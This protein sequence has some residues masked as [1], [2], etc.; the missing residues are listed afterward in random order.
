MQLLS[1]LSFYI[2]VGMTQESQFIWKCILQGLTVE[3]IATC[4]VLLVHEIWLMD[5]DQNT[6]W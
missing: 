2:E 6:E 3:L 4:W 5:A 1:Q